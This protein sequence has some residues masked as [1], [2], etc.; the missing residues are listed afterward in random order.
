[1][2]VTFVVQDTLSPALAEMREKLEVLLAEFVEQINQLTEDTEFEAAYG[3][4]LVAQQEEY[5]G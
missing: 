5:N 3:P 2:R 1:M 4:W